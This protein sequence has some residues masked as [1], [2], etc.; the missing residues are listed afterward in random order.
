MS[1]RGHGSF[2]YSHIQV[3][4]KPEDRMNVSGAT[5]NAAGRGGGHSVVGGG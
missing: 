2:S 4:K 5:V 1:V 3:F